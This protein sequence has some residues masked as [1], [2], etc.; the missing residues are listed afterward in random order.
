M[1]NPE[2]NKKPRSDHAVLH[3]CLAAAVL[4]VAFFSLGACGDEDFTVGGPLPSRPT[5]DATN[6]SAT[7]DDDF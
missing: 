2:G 6:P 1:M 5:V 3:L 7:P 4:A